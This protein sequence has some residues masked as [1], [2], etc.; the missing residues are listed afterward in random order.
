MCK[1]GD[2]LFLLQFHSIERGKSQSYDTKKNISKSYDFFLHNFVIFYMILYISIFYF[3]ITILYPKVSLVLQQLYTHTC[4]NCKTGERG[5]TVFS[6]KYTLNT[7]TTIL[8]VI[9]KASILTNLLNFRLGGWIHVKD[10][11][12]LKNFKKKL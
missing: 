8:L 11:L 6:L 4:S 7:R 10:R 12:M 3:I 1:K 5:K 9:A 2:I